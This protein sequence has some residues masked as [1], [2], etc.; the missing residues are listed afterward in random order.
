MKCA[1][2]WGLSLVHP[3]NSSSFLCA[4]HG[5]SPSRSKESIQHLF[6]FVILWTVWLF[7]N[8]IIFAN[9]RRDPTQLFF[10]VGTRAA[11]WFKAIWAD[12]VL[13]VESMIADPS[14]DDTSGYKSLSSLVVPSWRT[15]PVGF[16]NLNVDGAM[17]RNGSKGGIS[18]IIR[19]S[20]GDY[21]DK[22]SLS[23]GS[24]PSISA[25]LLA[26]EHGLNFFFANEGYAKFRLILECDCAM[27]VE[28]RLT[29]LTCV[30]R[31]S[32]PWLGGVRILSMQ[33]LSYS[34]SFRGISI[35]RLT[36]TLK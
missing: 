13:C 32:N 2:F 22:F 1:A 9:G 30:C 23:I 17:L 35:W 12:F 11:L 10:L 19:N 29:I 6:P 4:W 21:L 26:I 5:A 18:G 27:T 36:P 24:R 8:N 16:L 20:F 3:G 34:A 33:N 14:I 25:E 28:W 7:R 31:F 15:P